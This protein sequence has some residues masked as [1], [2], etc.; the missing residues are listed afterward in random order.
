MRLL[1]IHVIMCSEAS[2][3]V[4]DDSVSDP[5]SKLSVSPPTVR[6]TCMYTNTTYIQ[7]S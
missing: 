3:T 5:S 1:Y 4:D 2:E 7:N 6:Q